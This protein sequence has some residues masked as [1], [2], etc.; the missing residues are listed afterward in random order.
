MCTSTPLINCG[1]V[2]DQSQNGF[3][4]VLGGGLDVR[5]SDKIDLRVVQL[6]YNPTV[7][8]ESTSTNYRIGFGIVFK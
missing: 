8:D 2:A 3:A 4:A 1:Q 7:F 6:D 5:L